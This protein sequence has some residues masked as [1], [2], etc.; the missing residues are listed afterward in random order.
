MPPES[1]LDMPTQHLRRWSAKDERKPVAPHLNRTPW[2]AR[3]FVFGGALGLT[4]YGAYEMYQ[5]VSVSRTT[6]LQWLLLVLFTIN[7][8][9]IALAFT[10]ALL[11]FCVLLRRPKA[12]EPLPPSLHH[13]TAV[14]MPVYNESTARTFAAI[15]AI[16]ESIEAT[17]SA[18]T[19]TISSCRIPRTR[20]PGSRRSGPTSRCA[21]ASA[22]LP[23]LLPAPARRT[24]TARPAT[25]RTS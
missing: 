19:S 5:V 25:S 15:E 8:S 3:L 23:P 1:H 10:S 24:I 14:V 6:V 13:R 11:G 2:L 12:P 9:W 16:R 4:A 18:G 20:M 22:R 17:G 7:F 21:S